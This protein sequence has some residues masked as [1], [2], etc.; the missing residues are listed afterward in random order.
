MHLRDM[1]VDPRDIYIENRAEHS[2]ENVFYSMEIARNAGFA[3][4]AVATDPMQSR[5]ISFLLRKLDLDVDYLPA[6][7]ATVG[8]EYWKGFDR[9]VDARPAMVSNFVPLKDREERTERMKGTKGEKY[10]LRL[11][12]EHDAPSVSSSAQ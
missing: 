5:M 3:K 1:G 11:K 2:T 10:L 9:K 7:I 8:R 12:E 4:V 6:D